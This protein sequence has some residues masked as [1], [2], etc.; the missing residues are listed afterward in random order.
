MHSI[1]RNFLSLSYAS[2]KQLLV[3]ITIGFFPIGFMGAG[4]SNPPFFLSLHLYEALIMV[5]Y[6]PSSLKTIIKTHTVSNMYTD[7]IN[8]DSSE[9]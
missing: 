4:H 5:W 1:S 6:L 8:K 3:P 2:V 9:T 7:H